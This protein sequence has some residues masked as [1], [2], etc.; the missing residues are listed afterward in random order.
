MASP[1]GLSSACSCTYPQTRLLLWSVAFQLSRDGS[2]ENKGRR[3]MTRTGLILHN[4]VWKWVYVLI[5]HASN[6]AVVRKFYVSWGQ[7]YCL[8]RDRPN[9]IWRIL[10]HNLYFILNNSLK[11]APNYWMTSCLIFVFFLNLNAQSSVFV[12][13]RLV[14]GLVTQ[15][16]SGWPWL[17]SLIFWSE[18]SDQTLI[19]TTNFM[20]LANLERQPEYSG[21]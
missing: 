11:I 8:S 5:L 7:P 19:W 17:L 1:A 10:I 3:R 14:S 6:I 9:V 15:W 21:G 16:L 12:Y 18:V 13:S 2:V 4:K 20:T